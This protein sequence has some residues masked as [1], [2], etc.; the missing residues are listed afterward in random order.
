MISL[1]VDGA[2]VTVPPGATLLD[3]ARR[4]GADLPTLCHMDG[5]SPAGSCRLCVV[6]LAGQAL[7][8]TACD[9]PCAE[10]MAVTTTDD[11]LAAQRRA[12]LSLILEGHPA[13]CRDPGDP[14]GPC[15]LERLA[16]ALGIPLP[17]PGPPPAVDRAHPAI[18]FSL[19]ACI[20]CGRCGRACGEIQGH[21]VITWQGRAA[22]RRLAF[23]GTDSLAGSACVACGQCV[24]SCPTGALSAAVAPLPRMTAVTTVCPYCGVGCQVTC[25]VGGGAI[26]QVTSPPD[27][28]ANHGRLCVKG[29]FGLDFQHHPGRL[30]TP[31]VR[32]DGV[33]G[34]CGPDG[35]RPATWD[36]AL[37]LAATRLLEAAR[38]HGGGAVGGLGSAKCTNEDNYL[39]QKWLRAGLGTHNVDH[40]A[41]LCHS[42]SVVALQAMLGSGAATNP[43]TD[44]L[45]ADTI[46]LIGTNTLETHPV[47]A[48]FIRQAQRAGTTLVV[49]DPRRV[50]LAREADIHLQHRPGSDPWLVNG[51]ARAVLDAGLVD[52]AFITARTE[53]FEV[54]RDGLLAL[55]PNE[56][57]TVT[58]VPWAAIER[59]GRAIGTAGA[60]LTGWGMGITQHVAGSINCAAV[61]GLALL[62]GNLGRPGAGL[63]PLRGQSNVQGA[64]DMGVLPNVLPGYQDPADPAVRARFATAWGV[65]LP[66][67]PGLTV[68]EMMRAA[69]D[70]GLRALHVM[71]ENPALSDPDLD[72]VKAGLARLD[73]LVVQD[74]FFTETCAHAHVILPAASVLERD[75]SVTNTERR[76]QQS[77]PVLPPPGQAR[78]D[79]DI[80][81][82][83]MRRA[84][85]GAASGDPAAALAEMA[86]LTPSHG[87]LSTARLR[88][89]DVIWPCPTAAHPGT[90]ILHAG[91]AA[92]GR[93]RFQPPRLAAPAEAPDADFPL[94]LTTGRNLY[95]YQT[96]TM[97][98]RAPVLD[99]QVPGAWLEAH[100]DTLARA[101]AADGGSVRLSTRRGTI[102]VTAR[103]VDDA[104]P[105]VLFVPFHFA[106]TPVNRLIHDTLDPQSKIPEYKCV[107]ARIEP[108]DRP[109]PPP[110]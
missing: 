9:T 40:C 11:G 34:P 19:A 52:D 63:N 109:A 10:G 90:P 43:N 60:A 33:T 1:T 102:Q 5:M 87:G 41:R 12:T 99:A 28:P 104:L 6:R 59:A 73:T 30:T 83:L 89:G 58:G 95:H 57:A 49:A 50:G 17:A 66:T 36:A 97:S 98:R 35:F 37:D 56:V 29:R 45:L 4:S 74:I 107:A 81:A 85:M 51:L 55:D 72:H 54:Y 84:G 79:G 27:S 22:R 32:R 110:V 86:A 18:H 101:G 93:A 108:T 7:P 53:G 3:A 23:S 38:R 8:V 69:A 106:E 26:R 80:L 77:V 91:G 78:A 24:A 39:F 76:I 103:A 14:R 62:T 88:K 100:P 65:E 96:G 70:G 46:F 16:G 67:A 105:G 47:I 2:P 75:G 92:R 42:S 20:Q 44:F 61:A 31:L 82:E 94:L 15:E 68:V 21:G 71:G 48:T 25:H 64:S 13:P